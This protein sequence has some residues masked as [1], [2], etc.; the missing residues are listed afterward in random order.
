MNEILL[1]IIQPVLLLLAAPLFSGVSRVLRAKMHTRRG[2]SV[3]Q[4]YYDLIKLFKREDVRT[5]DSGAPFLFMPVY[6]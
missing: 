6:F 1:A 5:R 2:P 4:D 3:F